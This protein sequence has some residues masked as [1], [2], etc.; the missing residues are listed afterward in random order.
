MRTHHSRIDVVRKKP[1][2]SH[3]P[4]SFSGGRLRPYSGGGGSSASQ[5]SCRTNSTGSQLTEAHMLSPMI[6]MAM[7]PQI[8]EARPKPAQVDR[9]DLRIAD[10]AE[11]VVEAGLPAAR[12]VARSSG[13]PLA[14]AV[15][16]H[17]GEDILI[18]SHALLPPSARPAGSS[19]QVHHS[20]QPRV[21]NG[22]LMTMHTALQK[23]ADSAR[24]RPSR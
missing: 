13:T 4:P 16:L 23:P 10:L 9:A 17:A 6:S 5:N 19:H 14:G 7:K 1:A 15:H 21:Q 2:I 8:S 24:N 3:Q 20:G 12:F 22:P 11:P 18:F